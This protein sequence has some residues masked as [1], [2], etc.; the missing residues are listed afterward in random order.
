MCYSANVTEA[1]VYMT[2]DSEECVWKET[3]TDSDKNFHCAYQKGKLEIISKFHSSKTVLIDQ[4]TL[5]SP[6]YCVN[7]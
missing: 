1:L 6:A 2:C 3:Q 4:S 5:H 7:L